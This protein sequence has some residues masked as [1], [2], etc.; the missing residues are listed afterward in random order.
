MQW[1]QRSV[2][3][4]ANTEGVVKPCGTPN[5]SIISIERLPLNKTCWYLS[6]RNDQIEV[7][8]IPP[9]PE[10]DCSLDSKMS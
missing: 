7:R 10:L 3:H 8:V 6:V 2:L 1:C 9:K 5:K 4:T